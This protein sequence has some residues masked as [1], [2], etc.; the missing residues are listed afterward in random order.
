MY[1]L[2]TAIM[3]LILS[4]TM[5]AIACGGGG[6]GGGDLSDPKWDKYFGCL[7]IQQDWENSKTEA[8]E[9]CKQ[10]RP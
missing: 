8:R 7:E 3:L 9:N 5:T 10:Y 1:R 2:R 6:G 4:L